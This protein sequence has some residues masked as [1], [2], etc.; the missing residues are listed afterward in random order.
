YRILFKS[1]PSDRPIYG[2]QSTG[3]DG[4]SAL[5]KSFDDMIYEY[6]LE[7]MSLSLNSPLTFIGGSMGGL[8]A[9]E[10]ANFLRQQGEDIEKL[11][12]LDTFGPNYTKKGSTRKKITCSKI[13][14]KLRCKF[15]H[16]FNKASLSFYKLLG[17]S[18]PHDL[19]FYF[20]ELNNFKLMRNHKVSKY[21]DH[22]IMIRGRKTI[23]G[24]SADP[25]LGWDGMVGSIEVH[26]TE[27]THDE[28]VESKDAR[29]VLKEILSK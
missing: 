17:R 12:M 25:N 29:S 2:L 13:L 18:I 22:L 23:S 4:V 1:I 14:E 24:R 26:Y 11:I 3:I 5:C 9:Y 21:D 10:V 6:F 19:R 27:S 28:I 16:Y 15:N 7:I 20:V 8:V